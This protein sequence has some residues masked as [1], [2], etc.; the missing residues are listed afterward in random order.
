MHAHTRTHTHT[1]THGCACVC[2][3]VEQRHRR[4]H[5]ECHKTMKTSYTH[6]KQ[7]LLSNSIDASDR[8]E[9]KDCNAC[10]HAAD[11]HTHTGGGALKVGLRLTS[12]ETWTRASRANG[13]GL[14]GEQSYIKKGFRVWSCARTSS[15]EFNPTLLS[16]TCCRLPSCIQYRLITTVWRRAHLSPFRRTDVSCVPV[17]QGYTAALTPKTANLCVVVYAK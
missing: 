4:H 3:A 1:R 8:R 13:D 16:M 2:R 17:G 11:T 15:I 12:T 14:N 10:A 5:R 7:T 9:C 6:T